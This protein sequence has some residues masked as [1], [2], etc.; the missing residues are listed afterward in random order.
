MEDSSNKARISILIAS[1]LLLIIVGVFALVTTS[2][3]AE[4]AGFPLIGL[5]NLLVGL[6]Y[7]YPHRSHKQKVLAISAS[8]ASL[9][10]LILFGIYWFRLLT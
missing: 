5:G 8:A 7:K 10:G 1:G 6:S 9:V 3:K 4:W 2:D